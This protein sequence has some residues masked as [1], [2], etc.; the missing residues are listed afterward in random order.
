M[1]QCSG[2]PAEEL[3]A[4]YLADELSEQQSEEFEDHYVGCNRCHRMVLTLQQVGSELANNTSSAATMPS[5]DAQ[6]ETSR[7]K[8]LR[9]PAPFAGRLVVFGA[10]AAALLVAAILTGT[11]VTRN[12]R[13]TAATSA[14]N[15]PQAAQQTTQPAGNPPAVNQLPIATPQQVE[16]AS[17]ADMHL[18]GYEPGQLRDADTG[19]RRDFTAGMQSYA[20]DDCQAALARL[21]KT[22]SGSEDA[23]SAS[24][25]GGLCQLKTGS[26]ARAESSFNHVIA[27]GDTPQL[28][29]AEYFLAQA[30]LMQNDPAG[31]R[32]WL[33]KTAALRGDYELRAR[34]QL[35]QLAQLP[36]KP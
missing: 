1:T 7:G 15:T 25:Y 14:A 8:V 30:R 35:K 34:R 33:N 10:L 4:L 16:V 29:T 27:A 31:A 23:L 32:N 11:L 28:E 18:P 26:S 21:A 13:S 2:G 9:F 3:A 20:K 5:P 22:P 24:L 36:Q 6:H 19:N 17:L 12:S